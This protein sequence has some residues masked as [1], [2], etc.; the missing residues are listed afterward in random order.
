MS[1][2]E[3]TAAPQRGGFDVILGNPPWERPKPEPAKFFAVR[4]PDISQA[5]TSAAR[6][7][8]LSLLEQQDPGLFAD[9]QNHER[10]VMGSV[11]L[12][13]LSGRFPLSSK[14]KFNL[15]NV[16]VECATTHLSPRGRL[17]VLNVSGLATDDSGRDFIDDLLSRGALVSFFDFENRL[18]LF[19]AV[20]ASYRFSA[21]T[22]AGVG[23]RHE[24]A[25]FVFQA[26][27][28]S[29]LLNTTRHVSITSTDIALLNPISRTCPV[30]RSRRDADLV[31][32]I[33][34][35]ASLRD[36]PTDVVFQ[37]NAEPTFLFVMSDHSGLFHTRRS[38]GDLDLSVV[39]I[40]PTID[41]CR[42]L[43]LYE[44][45]MF[46]QFDHRW[47]ALDDDGEQ[48][49]LTIAQRNDPRGLIWPHFWMRESD[50]HKKIESLPH[51]WLIAV[52]EVTNST[53]ERTTIAA[54][55]PKY[56]VGHNAQVFRFDHDARDACFFVGCLNSF[57]FDFAARTKVGGSHLSSFILRQLPIL[58]SSLGLAP[59]PWERHA[60]LRDWMTA[61]VL[62][63]TFTV[64]DVADF[65][66]ECQ[67][68]GPPFRWQVARRDQIRAELDAA[69]LHLYGIS[70]D[71]AAYILNSFT[72]FRGRDEE[73]NG[74]SYR[75][76]EN[77]LAIYD[78]LA[79]AIE[80]GQDWTSPL[81]PPPGDPR[82]AH[83]PDT[84]PPPP[85][86]SGRSSAGQTRGQAEAPKAK[87]NGVSD[88]KRK[89]AIVD[90]FLSVREGRSADFVVCS[91][92][93]NARF[94][95]TARDLGEEGT[96]A[97]LNR[98]LL[99][100][101]K[102]NRLK[103]HPTTV[104]FTLPR[105]V[106]PYAFVGEWAARHLQRRMLVDHN[107]EVSLDNILCDPSLA[108]K[109]DECAGRIKPGVPPLHWRWA[110]LAFRKT[111]RRRSLG[112]TAAFKLRGAARQPLLFD[113]VPPVA[114]LYMLTAN[115][116]PIYVNETRDLHETILRHAE[117]G[118]GELVPPWLLD[119]FPTADG[120]RWAAL[121]GVNPD[122]LHEGRIRLVANERPWLNLVDS[123]TAA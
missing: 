9:W 64:I 66:L 62:E 91:A 10:G 85:V 120:V 109:F 27:D 72:V 79:I 103:D 31:K 108:A 36:D 83:N 43:P 73:R 45:K 65:A 49:D 122:T 52:R 93:L 70:R 46:H 117:V 107:E 53:N 37:W 54:I 4:R 61:R 123:F 39:G 44:S 41:G 11:S 50:A 121:A 29:V 22:I 88:A 96:D 35:R 112:T 87:P 32:D 90:A 23:T 71:D 48:V 25:D 14:G 18:G 24:A 2:P 26:D 19:P 98:R 101:R 92:E 78:Q 20:H 94:L 56:P 47:A 13:T 105:Q 15:G 59:V 89:S 86:P 110:A 42:Y 16:F 7:R 58:P 100:A 116:R 6:D 40:C 76:R 80:R 77:I 34:R 114:G 75:T 102:T 33:Y 82:A 5:P 21:I 67:Y 106:L 84:L 118:G 57:V 69:F 104:G 119:Q 30:F 3:S 74:G 95:A 68:V 8:L 115:G 55:L 113:A 81:D 1:Q 97:E 38:L 12:M 111:G 17:G 63:L 60:Q 28:P 99:S 51:P